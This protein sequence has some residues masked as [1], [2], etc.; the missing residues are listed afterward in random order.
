MEVHEVASVRDVLRMLLGI[1]EHPRTPTLEHRTHTN[2]LEHRQVQLGQIDK[3][4]GLVGFKDLH[5]KYL[6]HDTRAFKNNLF[7]GLLEQ[8]C[9]MVIPDTAADYV[10]SLHVGGVGNKLKLLKKHGYTV[11]MTAVHA[12]IRKCTSNG[13]SRERRR[14]NDTR[15]ELGV[16]P[17][18]MWPH[19]LTTA[20]VLVSRGCVFHLRQHR[21]V[22]H[23]NGDRTTW[24]ERG[25]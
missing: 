14:V 19:S 16:G 20:V 9:N 8:G 22:Q 21:L 24:Y 11:V 12:S 1:L 15:V 18:K 2:I 17:R 7:R 5:S 3:F 6:K 25:M 10:T 23:E 13:T 4:S